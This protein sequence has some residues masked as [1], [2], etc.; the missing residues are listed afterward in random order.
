VVV[1]GLDTGEVETGTSGET[2]LSVNAEFTVNQR[3]EARSLSRASGVEGIIPVPQILVGGDSIVLKNEPDKFGSGVVEVKANLGGGSLDSLT[4]VVLELLNKILVGVLGK[5]LASIVI[6]EHVV[7][8]QRSILDVR[9]SG[10]ERRNTNWRSST[11]VA[12]S[13]A[14][15]TIAEQNLNLNLMELESNQRKSKT[16][17][18]I[19][20]ETKRNIQ[21]GSRLTVEIRTRVE[22][23]N[24]RSITIL[25]VA[26]AASLETLFKKFN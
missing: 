11:V 4:L 2:V 17:V 22:S 19:E 8:P 18:N 23:R 24:T 21:T 26:S 5:V 13:N 1:V 14:F 20:P 10:A 9:K 12:E 16:W 7:N 25:I 6:K 3:A 15:E